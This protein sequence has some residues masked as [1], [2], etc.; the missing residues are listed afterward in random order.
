MVDVGQVVDLARYPVTDLDSPAAQ[1]VIAA[2]AGALRR[3]GIS[4]LPGFVTANAVAAM[5]A[6]C[7]ALAGGAHHQDV[8][9]TPYLEVPNPS[10]WPDGHPRTTW[11]RSSVHT[12]AYDRFPPDSPIRALYEWDAFLD[13]L[14][15]VLGRH[16]LHRYADPLGALNLAVMVDGDELAWHYDQTDVVVSLA[17]Q[18]SEEGG[19]FE[20]VA[21]L[22]GADPGDERYDEVAAVL[23]DDPRARKRV[24]VEA[25]TP[26]TLMV[27]EG[28]RSLHRVTPIHGSTPRYVALLG[29][30]TKPDT[31][32]SDLLKLVRYGRTS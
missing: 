12:V 32:S 7:D 27:F 15:R 4:V 24:V 17:I 6:E 1:A 30:D 25:M 16:P 20:N 31:V 8:L 18:S 22:R 11:A 21:H 29:Y 23:R 14:S 3:R 19:L 2:H 5:V 9:G 13:F 28:R 10:D 26:G